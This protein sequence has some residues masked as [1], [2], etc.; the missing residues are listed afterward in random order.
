MDQQRLAYLKAMEIPVWELRG[1]APDTPRPSQPAES[2]QLRE[3]SPAQT[4][5]QPQ[6]RPQPEPRSHAGRLHIGP[7]DGG[8][9]M[10]CAGQGAS[11]SPL[12]CDIARAVQ[13]VP[14]WAWPR[15]DNDGPTAA[16]AVGESLFTCLVVFGHALAE[17]LFGAEPP[18]HIGSARVCVVDDLDTLRRSGDARRQLWARLCAGGVVT[19]R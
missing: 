10:V 19:P 18:G 5:P 11:T 6:V 7:G 1:A 8:T 15:D 17:R 13:D 12:A 16:E 9:L 2:P 4:R 3:Q 14:V